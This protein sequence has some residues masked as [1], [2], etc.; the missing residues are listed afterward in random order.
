MRIWRRKCQAS[1]PVA[2][3]V[4]ATANTMTTMTSR[5]RSKGGRLTVAERS[6]KAVSIPTTPFG[7]L[8][9][10]RDGG[11]WPWQA[12]HCPDASGGAA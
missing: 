12:A 11:F 1:E 10:R 3:T 4:N 6:W 7:G 2:H 8:P 5:G 9:K